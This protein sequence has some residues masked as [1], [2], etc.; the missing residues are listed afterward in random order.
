VRDK[1]EREPWRLLLLLAGI[2]AASVFPAAILEFLLT[3]LKF[4]VETVGEAFYMAFIVAGG[5]EETIKFAF[6]YYFTKRL[7]EFQEEYDGIMY[8]VAVG[9]GFAT[10]ENLVYVGAAL[11]GLGEMLTTAVGRAFTA[12]PLHA[13]NGV[14]MGYFLG[15]SHFMEEP[16]GRLKSNF[17]GVTLAILFHGI[18]D[19]FA[20]MIFVLP[21]S[22]AGWSVVGLFWTLFVQWGTSLKL[23][24]YAQ[25]ASWVR[26]MPPSVQVDVGGSSLPLSR[27][28]CPYCGYEVSSKARYC[29]NCGKLLA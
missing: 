17:M 10:L 21:P 5:V 15:R 18:Y 9:L 7:Q 22:A 6:V 4:E 23:V 8:T 20:L 1:W 19:F 24:R 14:I 16:E 29:V 3:G 2:G 26:H 11:V 25:E 27:R 13:L 28:F 12:V